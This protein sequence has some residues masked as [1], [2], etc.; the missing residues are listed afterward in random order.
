VERLRNL[1]EVNHLLLEL[2]AKAA[3]VPAS[4]NLKAA[5]ATAVSRLR[6]LLDPD[7]VALLLSDPTTDDADKC[8]QVL[9]AEGVRLPELLASDELPPALAEAMNSLGPVCRSNVER[10]EGVAV[11]TSSGLYVP[12]WARDCLIGLLAVER[13]NDAK[14]FANADL[15]IVEG[16]A[17]HAGLAIDNARW[18]RRLRTL[19][20]EEERGRIARE[21]H[22]RVGQ[23]LAY[24][25]MSLDRL[26]QEIG[27]QEGR[28]RHQEV[29]DELGQLAS[30]VR[31]ATGDI[32]TKLSDLRVEVAQG[33]EISEALGGLLARVEQRSGIGTFFLTRGNGSLSPVVERE[34]ARIAQEAIN[35]AERHAGA[36][37]IGVRWDCD[38]S[39]AELE[40]ADDGRGLAATAPLRR[41]AFGILGMRERAEAIGA[42]LAIN[43]APGQGTTVTLRVGAR[44]DYVPEVKQ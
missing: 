37:H 15:E 28:L 31:R 30:E 12:L 34:V 35:N 4:L 10:G 32:R 16:V 11:E 14:P 21:L 2:H 26:G 1:A 44:R 6:G 36:G 3:S 17:R 27:D 33:G 20:A 38:P 41:D 5:V 25:A 43:S 42:S 7:V 29:V 39:G 9:L 40:V 23:S 18:F 22:D 24:V 19:G 8:W 13:V